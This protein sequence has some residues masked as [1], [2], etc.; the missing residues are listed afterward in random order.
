MKKILIF[1]FATALSLLSSDLFIQKGHYSITYDSLILPGNEKL[2]LLGTGYLYDFDHAYLGLGVYSAVSGQRGGFFTGGLEAGY[3]YT[4]GRNFSLDAGVFA[5]G[6][7]GGS[8]PQ[9]GGLMLR[10]HIA[11]LYTISGYKVGLGFSKVKFPNGNIDSNQVFL[12]LSIPFEAVHKK[13]TNSPMILDDISDFMK[14][15]HTDMG[16]SDSYFAVTLQRYMIPGGVKNTSGNSMKKDMSLV[17]F[18]YG[19]ELDKNLFLFGEAAGAAGGGTDGYAEVSGGIGYK[20]A[21]TRHFGVYAKA[22]LGAAGGGKVDTGGGVIHK[23]ALGLY[24]KLNNKFSLG[25]E[26]G[27]IGAFDGNFK[28]TL[29]KFDFNYRLKSLSIGK[30]LQPLRS[31]QS[32][33]DYEWNFE[34]SNQYY[35]GDKSIRKNSDASAL[36][37]IGFK[38]DK[39]LDKNFYI[40]GQALGAYSGHSGG[41]AV[42]L[43]GLGRRIPVGEKINL[44]AQM[45]IGVAGGGSVATGN[46]MIYQPM[47][48]AE[49]KINN[50][51]GVQT[52][53]GKVKAIDGNLD[54]MAVDVGFSYKFR[55]IN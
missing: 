3:K 16:W 45:S 21:F 40:S 42:G 39:Y 27:H 55:T 41:Y 15:T 29:L 54:T 18:E 19:Y 51:F 48:G 8:A 13:N 26:V 33:G 5:G 31:Y 24:A 20:K 1:T 9:G 35:L 32:F 44:F 4:L 46:G 38:I 6:G 49:Y 43:V 28:A 23:E 17:G 25:F 10:P 11:L 14:S 47:I 7:G 37:L 12:Q 53:F 52:S 22:S 36:S 34:I 50:S 2:G 30:N